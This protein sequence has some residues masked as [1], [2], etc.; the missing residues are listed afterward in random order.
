MSQAP[1]TK[2]SDEDGEDT[3]MASPRVTSNTSDTSMGGVSVVTNLTAESQLC[4]LDASQNRGLTLLGGSP[5]KR[6]GAAPREP[7]VESASRRD[8]ES[9]PRREP[10]PRP[11]HT[12]PRQLATPRTPLGQI[13]LPRTPP[14][15]IT[16]ARTPPT[17]SPS[18]RPADRQYQGQWSATF[19]SLELLCAA[20]AAETDEIHLAHAR[21]EDISTTF[22]IL[23]DRARQHLQGRRDAES[24]D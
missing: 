4:S 16:A 6:N 21:F 9:A 13:A 18:T 15:K 10:K 11:P 24:R 19:S 8:P 2:T 23:I 5:S 17:A 12:P 7:V 22:G 3:H 1:A 14:Q 20:A